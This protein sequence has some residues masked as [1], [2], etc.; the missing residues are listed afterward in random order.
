M[1]NELVYDV[2]LRLDP[3]SAKKVADELSEM[4]NLAG[5]LKSFD[6]E[7]QA[8]KKAEQAIRAKGNA[9]KQF[10]KEA[11]DAARAS[12][13]AGIAEE[14]AI[15]SVTQE[16]RAQIDAIDLAQRQ[17]RIDASEAIRQYDA[18]ETKLAS[19]DQTN[20][21]VITRQRQLFFASERA[22]NGFV[23]M[24]T[25]LTNLETNSKG[26]TIALSNIGRIAQ[27]LPFGFIGISNNIDPLLVSFR[28]LRTTMGGTGGAIRAILKLLGGPMGMVFLLGSILPSAI[29]IAQNGIQGFGKKSKESMDKSKESVDTY[30]ESL[31]SAASSGVGAFVD[32]FANADQKINALT[33]ALQG[34]GAVEIPDNTKVL[35]TQEAIVEAMRET[36][37]GQKQFATAVQDATRQLDP[38]SIKQLEMVAQQQELTQAVRDELEQRLAVLKA[39]QA[40]Q[41]VLKD[42]GLV[43]D[44]RAKSRRLAADETERRLQAE[45]E[46]AYI[47]NLKGSLQETEVGLRFVFKQP[48]VSDMIDDAEGFEQFDVQAERIAQTTAETYDRLRLENIKH[49][50][51]SGD[52]AGLILQEQSIHLAN[53]DRNR[54]AL[55]LADEE[56]YQ[57]ARK[58]IMAETESQMTELQRKEM[59]NRNKLYM[60]GADMAI[61]SASAVFGETKG[62]A[63]AQTIIDT[64]R[65]A[66]GAFAGTP[67]GI[68]AKSLAAGVAVATGLANVRKIMTTTRKTRSV[69]GGDSPSAPSVSAP[70][71]PTFGVVDTNQISASMGGGN[72][73][74]PVLILQGDLDSELLAIKVRQGSDQLSS[75]GV[76]VVSA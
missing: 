5:R 70:Q 6:S 57:L 46:S 67:G 13:T 40:I 44:E 37:S 15:K 28:E 29:L 72:M 60:M 53:L 23:T 14:N 56:A 73:P 16:I 63:I 61:A 3:N 2:I 33:R 24:S 34:F 52:S 21:Q 8:A 62:L 65:G 66:Q 12:Q 36:V 75:R 55:G 74:A 19:L 58:N 27:D 26:A 18:I 39:D 4:E 76:S 7:A 35:A 38:A 68:F 11:Q 9:N 48:D 64:W 51:A 32:S 31:K 1:N 50:R 22:R 41:K 54:L 45:R 20:Q 69:S 59:D 30:A 43:E 25:S 17:R 71:Q 42:M 47:R 10:A 49:L